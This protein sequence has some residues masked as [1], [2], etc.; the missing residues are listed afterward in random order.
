MN[1]KSTIMAKAGDGVLKISIQ[2]SVFDLTREESTKAKY[3]IE[4]A[5]AKALMNL[6]GYF[7]PWA[8]DIVIKK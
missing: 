4:E 2:L 3:E 5:I 1:A 7:K 6:D 8:R